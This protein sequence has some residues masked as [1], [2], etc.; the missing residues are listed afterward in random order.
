MVLVVLFICAFGIWIYFKYEVQSMSLLSR[1][2]AKGWDGVNAEESRYIRCS[3]CDG[4]IKRGH[5][6]PYCLK[7]R[8]FT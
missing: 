6:T 7:C 5:T 4:A 2:M 8:R 1:L 3:G